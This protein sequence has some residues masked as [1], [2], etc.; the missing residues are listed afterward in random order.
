M[1]SVFADTCYYI[2]LCNPKD[3][4]SA[5]AIEASKKCRD[6]V[7]TA[8]Y[9]ILELGKYLCDPADRVLFLDLVDELRGSG[10]TTVIEASRA[11]LESGLA[12]YRRRLDKSWSLT[13]CI[14]F[15]VMEAL[16]I[17]DALSCDKHFLQAGFSILMVN[18]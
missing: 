13:D 11:R 16:G 10:R 2:A 12:L 3:E 17:R 7:V 14:S 4:W 6:H 8:E 5:A 9:V 15:V 18:S 1:K